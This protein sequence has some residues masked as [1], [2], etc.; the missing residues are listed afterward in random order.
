MAGAVQ[1]GTARLLKSNFIE[2]PILGKTGTC[3][4]D[5]TRFGW[6]GSF[7]NT[8]YGRIVT[9]VFLEGGRPTFGP[10]AAEL[11]GV[12]YRNLYDHDFFAVKAPATAAQQATGAAA[13]GATQ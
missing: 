12:M 8:Q 3:S 4:K 6:F 1:Y 7:A 11:A 2:E 13:V 10:K 9:V 5:G